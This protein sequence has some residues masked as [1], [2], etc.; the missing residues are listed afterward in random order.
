MVSPP[1]SV[2][3]DHSARAGGGG[4]S[5]GRGNAVETRPTAAA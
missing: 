5:E 2:A 4:G 3:L 1:S